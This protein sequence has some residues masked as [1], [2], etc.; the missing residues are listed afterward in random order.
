MAGATRAVQAQ[1]PIAEL[2]N[3]AAVRIGPVGLAPVVKLTELGIDTNVYDRSDDDNPVGSFTSRM[4]PSVNAWLQSTRVRVLGHSQFDL[5]Y[6]KSLPQLNA[7]D[8]SNAGQID[9]VVNR[10]TLFALG[11]RDVA[12]FQRNL[13]IDSIAARRTDAVGAGAAVRL[14]GKT[15]IELAVQHAGLAY[16][17]NSLYL[18]TDL[19][20]QLNHT[21]LAES[22]AVRY[23]VTPLT[24]FSVEATHTKARFDSALD[25]D[26]E[27]LQ[28]WPSIG[29]SPFAI[30][31]GHAAIGLLKRTFATG[32]S[33][34]TGSN[35]FVD[36]NYVLLGRTRF[37]IAGSRRLEY[38]YLVGVR[39]YVS[40]GATVTVTQRLGDAWDVGGTFG[41]TRLSYR[42]QTVADPLAPSPVPDETVLNSEVDVG[43]NLKHAR[44]GFYASETQ[45]GT[46]LP[47]QFRG[48]QRY[49]VGA[50]VTYA[51]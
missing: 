45:R 43:Y 46:D 29:F 40:T 20:Q 38:S 6:F 5:Y 36:L 41:R 7:V 44:V 48:Y 9:L 51:F 10:V 12:R 3:N 47:A 8:S 17:P 28:V 27:D 2:P 49:R 30:V 42:Q 33:A 21:S 11:S 19:A 32:G 50:T 31:S 25:R 22:L 35:G 15:S 14:T 4:T 1:G 39:D 18:N 23:A 26:S 24:T 16:E 37:T 13:E 34:F